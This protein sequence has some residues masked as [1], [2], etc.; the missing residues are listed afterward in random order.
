M[1]YKFATFLRGEKI[2]WSGPS[3]CKGHLIFDAISREYGAKN[4]QKKRCWWFKRKSVYSGT[5]NKKMLLNSQYLST[6]FFISNVIMY[7]LIDKFHQVITKKWSVLGKNGKRAQ[8]IH[9]KKFIHKL[10]ATFEYHFFPLFNLIPRN[11]FQV[12]INQ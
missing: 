9:P 2:D 4:M 6:N 3:Y 5:L 11:Y 7:A 10:K 8:N 1:R 12:D